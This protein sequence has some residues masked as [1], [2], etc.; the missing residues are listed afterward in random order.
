[1]RIRKQVYE[2][3]PSDLWRCPVW[4]FALDEEHQEGQ[5]EATVRPYAIKEVLD[6]AS[7]MFV[8]RASFELCDGTSMQGYM[9][10]PRQ[11]D[12]DLGTVQPVIVSDQGQVTFWCGTIEPSEKDIQS[13]Y[14][15]LSKAAS[16]VFPVRYESDV[17]LIDGV[18]RGSIP[19]FLHLEDWKSGKVRTIR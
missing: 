1:M 9:T 10:P 12:T 2:L 8:I 7:G 16:E 11:G 3:S 13:N 6:P 19:G 4:E 14:A 18:V 5:D 17:P 15:V